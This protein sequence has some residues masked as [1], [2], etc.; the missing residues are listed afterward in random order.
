MSVYGKHELNSKDLPVFK[1]L[2]SKAIES[3]DVFVHYD[4]R[5]YS[6]EYARWVIGVLEGAS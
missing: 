1:E 2:L 4:D 6:I 3:E 5:K